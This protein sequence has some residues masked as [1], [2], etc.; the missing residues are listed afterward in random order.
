[1]LDIAAR[2]ARR[3]QGLVE[4][5]PLVGCVLADPNGRVL[6]IG[7]HKRFGG[8]HAEAEAIVAARA[9]GIDLR[10][11]T[12]FVTLEP[13]NHQG[14]TPP[15]ARALIEAGVSEVVIARPDPNPIAQGG[16]DA[17]RAAGVSVRFTDASVNAV[18]LTD[19]FVKRVGTGLP[20]VIAKWA[21][22]IDGRIATRT[23][24]S[25]WISNERS[26]AMVHRWR[27]RVDVVLTG[28]GTVLADDPRL[29]ARIGRPPRRTAI[30]AI[31]DAALRTPT[32][33]KFVRTANELPVVIFCAEDHA[34]SPRAQALR[35]SGVELVPIPRRAGVAASGAAQP[36]DL[37]HAL[38]WLVIERDA[39]NVLVEA[40]P[41]LVGSLAR[42]GLIDECRVFVAP[43]LIGDSAAIPAAE[44]GALARIGDAQRFIA[45]RPRRV[46][47][48]A[49]LVFR[50]KR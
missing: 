15:C 40:G 10:G 21:Q 25:K 39:S 11:A 20:W 32:T 31:V 16:A 4:P 43:I 19:P 5:N 2:A 45:D 13:C 35:A 48:D 8:P 3:A 22:S 49:L 17:L 46:G 29:D 7:H 28:I 36:L 37:T 47:D 42:Q 24:D 1:M 38:R 18:R 50:T 34:D 26:R 41:G 33:S 12:A 44:I 27:S 23:G 30:R 6:A 9:K 14:K